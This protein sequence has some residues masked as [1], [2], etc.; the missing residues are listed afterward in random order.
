MQGMLNAVSPNLYEQVAER[1]VRWGEFTREPAAPTAGN[2]YAPL[3]GWTSESGGWTSGSGARQMAGLG[4]ALGLAAVGAAW[5][6]PR[7]THATH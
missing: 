1:F 6:R 3:P 7:L 4:L 2:L 5:L